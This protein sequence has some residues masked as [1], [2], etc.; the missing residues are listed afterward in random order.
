MEIAIDA[1]KELELLLSG[2]FITK[3]QDLKGYYSNVTE[4]NAPPLLGVALPTTVEEVQSIVKIATRTNVTIHAISAGM[5]WGLGSKVAPTEQT[6]VVSVKNLKAI[7]YVNESLR[8]AVIEPGVSQ[9]ELSDYLKQFHPS[10]VFPVTGSSPDS[11]ILSNALERGTSFH[12]HRPQEVKNLEVVLMDGSIVRT[13]FWET[14]TGNPALGEELHYP[15]GLGPDITGLFSQ[16]NFGIITAGVVMLEPRPESLYLVYATLRH[17]QLLSF[18]EESKAMYRGGVLSRIIHIGNNKRMKIQQGDIITGETW[19][20]M[21][22]I[23]GSKAVTEIR[24]EELIKAWQS[25]TE[26]VKFISREE[27]LSNE[28]ITRQLLALHEGIPTTIFLQA[29]YKSHDVEQYP[30]EFDIDKGTVGM[31]CCLPIV[32][33]EGKHILEVIDAANEVAS[34]YNLRLASTINPI[35]DLYAEFVL[36]IYF[37]RMNKEEHAMAHACNRA[38]HKRLLDLGAKFYRLDILEQ[39]EDYRNPLLK[40]IVNE[41]KALFDPKGILSPG[42]YGVSL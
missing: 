18:I 10:V 37:D 35:N 28:P 19:T 15:Y 1:V 13:G 36:N 34:T 31:M 12:G 8:F 2:K 21:T 14:P 39:R 33:M 5:S 6:L 38:L 30:D 4:F 7:R 22:A 16:S 23:Q 25:C 11:G 24:K 3:E 29:M 32:P 26:E 9:K 27:D 17:E 20:A 42:R 41:L 40:P